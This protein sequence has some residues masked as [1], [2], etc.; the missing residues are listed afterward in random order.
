MNDLALKSMKK[1]KSIG[2]TITDLASLEIPMSGYFQN[3]FGINT[4]PLNL[5]DST[6]RY[7]KNF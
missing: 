7:S 5:Y 6:I 3:F 1:S 2:S 4:A